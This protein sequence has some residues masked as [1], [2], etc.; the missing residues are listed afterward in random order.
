[1]VSN[2]QVMPSLSRTLLAASATA[3]L[4]LAAT[5]AWLWRGLPEPSS[6]ETVH[7]QPAR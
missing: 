5:A 2:Q 4:L 7:A 6:P 3:A 1:M